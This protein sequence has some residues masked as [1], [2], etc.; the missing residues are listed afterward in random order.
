MY[1]RY[2][3]EYLTNETTKLFPCTKMNITKDKNGENVSHLEIIKA[4]YTF[5]LNKSFGQSLEI[6]PNNFIFVNTSDSEVCF[7]DQYSKSLQIED[8]INTLVVN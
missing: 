6:S 7:I 3:L 5:V 2:Y 4:L 1:T 8:K